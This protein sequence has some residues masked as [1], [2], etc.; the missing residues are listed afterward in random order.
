MKAI[1]LEKILC[2][3]VIPILMLASAVFLPAQTLTTLFGFSGPDGASPDGGLMGQNWWRAARYRGS[4][5][6]RTP[7]PLDF[8]SFF[9]R[10][11]GLLKPAFGLSGAFLRR[12]LT[13]CPADSNAFSDPG[14]T[15][16]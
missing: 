4:P 7:L 5:I 2:K 1:S 3:M 10:T 12:N 6:S 8:H 14:R 13:S 11:R 16:S 15:I 9:A